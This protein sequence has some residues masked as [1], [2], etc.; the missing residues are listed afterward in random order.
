M[1]KHKLH[2]DI[3][4]NYDTIKG[5]HLEK[6]ASKMLKDDEY[7]SKLKSKKMKGKFLDKF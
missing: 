3:V 7:F 4:N 6:L 2:D 5:K 1:K